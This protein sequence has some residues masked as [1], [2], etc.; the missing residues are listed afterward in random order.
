MKNLSTLTVT[1]GVL[2]LSFNSS[3]SKDAPK[4]KFEDQTIHELL[5]ET[6]TSEGIPGMI[7]AI[8]DSNGIMISGSAGVR[9]INSTEEFTSKDIIHL[10]SCTKAMTGTLLA[11]FITNNEITWETTII[12]VF[13][14][15][16]DVILQVYH[17]VTLHQLLTHRSGIQANA[18]NWEAFQDMEIIE[19]R[20]SIMKEN[21]KVE[22][23][24]PSGTFTYSNLGYMIAGCMA[25]RITGQSWETLMKTRIFDPL[26]MTSAGFGAPGTSN[27][28]DQPWGH[29]KSNGQWIAIQSDNPEAIGPA[30]TVHCNIEDWVKFIDLFLKKGNTSILNRNLL[31]Q[32][33]EPID[34]YACGWG[35][36]QREWAGGT[37]LSH[38]G[39]NNMWYV[40]VWVAPEINRAFIAG[41]NSSDANTATI[42]DNSIGQLIVLN[43]DNQ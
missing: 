36:V 26:G 24:I 6:V 23:Q 2:L 35:I 38:N 5:S 27:Q 11:T 9:K 10:G 32:L 18:T 40:S 8:A 34:D 20:L 43:Q 15:L 17:E 12:D 41:T 21:L 3:C 33:I 25:E 31:D 28:I 19:R 37:V 30:G 4:L 16:K 14:E 29:Y 22:S 1:L 13:P 42:C 39:S 7:A